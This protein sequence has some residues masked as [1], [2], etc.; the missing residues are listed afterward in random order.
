MSGPAN[1]QGALSL[2]ETL[3]E[4]GRRDSRKPQGGSGKNGSGGTAGTD[5][6][7]NRRLNWAWCGPRTGTHARQAASGPSSSLLS[8]SWRWGWRHEDLTLGP[9]RQA[10][11]KKTENRF[12]KGGKGGRRNVTTPPRCCHWAATSQLARGTFTPRLGRR[13]KDKGVSTDGTRRGSR[14]VLSEAGDS[15]STSTT[16]RAHNAARG[17][18]PET[19]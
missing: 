15:L 11:L 18:P 1:D 14:Q 8:V 19:Y 5:C 17:T 7:F 6:R 4:P 2:V 12:R 9:T 3:R 10:R 16:S 13:V